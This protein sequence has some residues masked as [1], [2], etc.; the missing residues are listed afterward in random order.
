MARGRY[1]GVD[2]GSLITGFGI[3]DV[4]GPSCRWVASGAIRTRV[5][6]SQEADFAHRLLTIYDGLLEVIDRHHPD[7][8][9][10]ET[11]FYGKNVQSTLKLGHVRGVALLGALHRGLPVFEY[12]PR[13][14]KRAVTGNGAS[15]K[16]QVQYMVNVILGQ[17][18]D[19]G[20]PDEAD[21]LAVALCHALRQQPAMASPRPTRGRGSRGDWAS[22]LSNHPERVISS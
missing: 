12:S 17:E 20:T 8:F 13:E 19:F 6:P 15:A 18:R 3:V 1:L 4:D 22:F 16:P 9:C 11:A 5:S 2:P 7:S 14:V 10:L 21:A